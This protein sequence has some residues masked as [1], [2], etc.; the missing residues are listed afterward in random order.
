M[1]PSRRIERYEFAAVGDGKPFVVEVYCDPDGVPV[2]VGFVDAAED[3]DRGTIS[4]IG[5]RADDFL[6]V[7]ELLE[8]MARRSDAGWARAICP[9]HGAWSRVRDDGTSRDHCPGCGPGP[10]PVLEQV[11]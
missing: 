2:D 11:P 10:E 4:V 1:K 8:D 3:E 9:E 5:M 7:A 6:R